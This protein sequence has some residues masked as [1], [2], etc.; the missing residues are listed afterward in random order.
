MGLGVTCLFLFPSVVC[1]PHHHHHQHHGKSSFGYN[2][3][4]PCVTIS[5]GNP[6]VHLLYERPS[7]PSCCFFSFVAAAAAAVPL[8]LINQTAHLYVG[9]RYASRSNNNRGGGGC[10]CPKPRDSPW[11]PTH[12]W[13]VSPPTFVAETWR[14]TRSAGALLEIIYIKRNE[15]LPDSRGPLLATGPGLAIR[16]RRIGRRPSTVGRKWRNW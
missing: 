4:K 1:C 3:I 12:F 8:F 10:A 9:L 11:L 15:K 16:C 7:S 14:T 13:Y 2:C 6:I 5:V